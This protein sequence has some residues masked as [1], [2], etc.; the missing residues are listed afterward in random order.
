MCK[1]SVALSGENVSCLETCLV[2]E[3]E[4]KRLGMLARKCAILVQSFSC[5]AATGLYR[6][7]LT[8]K[9]ENNSISFILFCPFQIQAQLELCAQ[10][11]QLLF[12]PNQFIHP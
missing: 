8:C 1:C 2:M 11:D 4:I 10:S 9:C 5:F 12:Y 7:M 3:R 6:K